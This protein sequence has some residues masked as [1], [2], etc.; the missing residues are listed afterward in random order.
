MP[1]NRRIARIGHWNVREGQVYDFG[2]GVR[3]RVVRIVDARPVDCD[4]EIEILEGEGSD[5]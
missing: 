1:E 5:A 2:D 4:V 3:G